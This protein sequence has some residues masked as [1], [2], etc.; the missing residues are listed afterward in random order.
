MA[1]KK[2]TKLKVEVDSFVACTLKTLPEEDHVPAAAMAIRVNPVNRPSVANVEGLTPGFLAVLTTKY[3]GVKG[4][5]LTVG[6]MEPTPVDLRERILLNMNSWSAF[7]NVKFVWTQSSP[8]IR[9][10]RS[11]DGYWSYL[12]TDVLSIPRNEP[13]MCLSGFTMQTPESEYRRVVKHETGHT[14]GFPHEHM[15]AELIARLDV[16]KTIA[17]FQRTQGWSETVTR[18]QV[19]TPLSESSLIGTEHADSDSIMCY[20]LPGSITKDGKPINGGADINANDRQFAARI[21]PSTILPPPPIKGLPAVLVAID[22][23]GTEM[24]RYTLKGA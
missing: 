2:S 14:L 22:E 8:Q 4:V 24:G 21:Y 10:T 15:R 20:Q 5:D 12:G 17:Y 13:T 7:S 9:I 19:L 6:F 16:R 11:G 23:N 18:Q 1:R 3:W